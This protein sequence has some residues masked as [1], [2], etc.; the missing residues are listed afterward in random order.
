M[1]K[2]TQTTAVVELSG[3]RG[4]RWDAARCRLRRLRAAL[5]AAVGLA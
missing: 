5:P 4:G 3:K 1:I 2:R